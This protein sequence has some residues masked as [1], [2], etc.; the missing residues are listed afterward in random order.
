VPNFFSGTSE[1]YPAANEI[2]SRMQ[3]ISTRPV[4][5]FE[6]VPKRKLVIDQGEGKLE[7]PAF[8]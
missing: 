4:L 8:F 7:E 1:E 3:H 2:I 6:N 5:Y